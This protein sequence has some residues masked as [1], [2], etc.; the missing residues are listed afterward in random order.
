MRVGLAG[1]SLVL[2]AGSVVTL[3]KAAAEPTRLRILLL[4]SQGEFSVKDLT[5]I[6]GQSQP[7]ISRHLKLLAEAGLIERV[8]EGSWAYFHL[9]E[10]SSSGKLGRLLIETI[11]RGEGSPARDAVRAEALKRERVE[12]AQQR[13]G[14]R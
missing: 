7:R 6:L 12:A 14:R 9:A 11:H 4:L 2:D 8:R 3:L 10:E 1:M 13:I 5:R